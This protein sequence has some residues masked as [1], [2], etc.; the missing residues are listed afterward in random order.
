MGPISESSSVP[1]L[2]LSARVRST[3]WGMMCSA[4][5]PT[6]TATEMAMQRSPAEPNAAPIRPSTAWS[7]SASGMTTM[8]FLAPPRA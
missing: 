8:W 4:T 2:I 7:K 5:G 1:F 3:S 6:N